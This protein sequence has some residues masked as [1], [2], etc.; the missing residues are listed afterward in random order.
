MSKVQLSAAL[1]LVTM[2]GLPVAAQAV[3]P[4]A[5]APSAVSLHAE[6]GDDGEDQGDD[7]GGSFT[8]PDVNPQDTDDSFVVPPVVIHPDGKRSHPFDKGPGSVPPIDGTPQ[9][10]SDLPDNHPIRVDKVQPST[11]TPT[12][13]FVDTAV[14]GLGAVG[15][16]ALGLGAVVGVRAIRA[17]RSGVKADYFYGD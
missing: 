17:R 8:A 4:V 5:S 3:T 15:A 6:H 10:L 9:T 11:K 7:E 1:V 14:I 12:D 13:L 2:F 16:G